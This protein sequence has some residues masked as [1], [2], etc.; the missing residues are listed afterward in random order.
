MAYKSLGNAYAAV[1]SA[2]VMLSGEYLPRLN[3]LPNDYFGIW[4]VLKP[5]GRA[6]LN[7]IGRP[8]AFFKLEDAQACVDKFVTPAENLLSKLSE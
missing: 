2:T 8:Q 7:D 4:Y 6:L 1:P 5:D 3:N